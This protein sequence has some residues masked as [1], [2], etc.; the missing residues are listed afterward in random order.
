MTTRTNIS[1][2]PID[3]YKQGQFSHAKERAFERYGLALTNE[4][5]DEMVELIETGKATK[6]A[7]FSDR[8]ETYYLVWRGGA[9][10]IGYDPQNKVIRTFLPLEA[11]SKTRKVKYEMNIKP[12]Y[13]K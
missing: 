11:I 3:V 13:V 10:K 6:V 1:F 9:L 2:Q 4:I 5:H 12:S 7:R 8:S